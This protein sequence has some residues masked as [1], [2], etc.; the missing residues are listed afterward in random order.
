MH[1]TTV[2]AAEVIR[3]KV[4][5]LSRPLE[6][7]FKVILATMSIQRQK[8]AGMFCTAAA[9]AVKFQLSK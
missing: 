4:R 3:L 2:K 7:Q 9:V 6:S 5:S 8:N 1:Y